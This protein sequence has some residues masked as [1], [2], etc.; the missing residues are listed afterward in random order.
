MLYP[1]LIKTYVYMSIYVCLYVCMCIY[2][3][4]CVCVRQ[5]VRARACACVWGGGQMVASLEFAFRFVFKI[6]PYFYFSEMLLD[7][8]Y[9]LSDLFRLDFPVEISGSNWQGS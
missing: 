2:I 7:K 1:N 5:S 4:V 9:A 3:C 6:A 8:Y